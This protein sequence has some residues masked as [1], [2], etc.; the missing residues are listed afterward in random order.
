[1]CHVVD[2]YELIRVEAGLSD[3]YSEIHNGWPLRKI[4]DTWAEVR[5]LMPTV[6]FTLKLLG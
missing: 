5:L 2:G 4:D 1:M 6:F 3:Y